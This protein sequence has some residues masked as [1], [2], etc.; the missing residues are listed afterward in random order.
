[1]DAPGPLRPWVMAAIC[2][3]AGL[4][5]HLLIDRP[6]D[7]PDVA[8]RDALAAFVAISA[9]VFVP[10][11]E[12]RRWHWAAG[13]SLLWGA[14]LGLIGGH[15]AGYNPNGSSMRIAFWAGSI[16]VPGTTPRFLTQP[17]R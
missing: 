7:A 13:F 8:W 2:A 15:S 3:V 14:V 11:V 6:Y 4:I 1:M 9:V 5:F 12:L 10:G 17:D 16:A